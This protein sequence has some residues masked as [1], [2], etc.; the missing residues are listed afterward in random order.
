MKRRMKPSLRFAALAA[1]VNLSLISD[2]KMLFVHASS[3]SSA[4]TSSASSLSVAPSGLDG[5]VLAGPEDAVRVGEELSNDKANQEAATTT[6]NRL[7]ATTGQGPALSP[8]SSLLRKWLSRS[9]N[10]KKVSEVLFSVTMAATVAT[11][12]LRLRSVS[13]MCMARTAES[14]LRAGG[15][16]DSGLQGT[17]NP[18]SPGSVVG[19]S[20][21]DICHTL[22]LAQSSGEDALSQVVKDKTVQ[23]GNL[24][25]KLLKMPV[26]SKRAAAALAV[27]VLVLSL[28]STSFADE[29]RGFGKRTANCSMTIYNVDKVYWTGQDARVCYVMFYYPWWAPLTQEYKGQA[30]V[31]TV[32]RLRDGLPY[33]YHFYLSHAAVKDMERKGVWPAHQYWVAVEWAEQIDIRGGDNFKLYMWFKPQAM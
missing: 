29:R 17:P 32:E 13:S 8:S 10:W 6:S 3:E 25:Q 21:R 26:S 1:V 11:L 4:A 20:V 27:A 2:H 7:R 5:K 16:R 18:S 23:S 28:A 19:E 33:R 22:G 30:K 31:I 15:G 14:K 12:L 24:F 9:S